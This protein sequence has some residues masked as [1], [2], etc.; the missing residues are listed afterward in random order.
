MFPKLLLAKVLGS[1]IT[2]RILR[3][4]DAVTVLFLNNPTS[5]QEKIFVHFEFTRSIIEHASVRQATKAGTAI[6]ISLVVFR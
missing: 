4:A 3:I 1:I 6:I 5:A 2:C